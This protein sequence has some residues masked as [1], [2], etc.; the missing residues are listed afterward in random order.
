[1]KNFKVNTL[2]IIIASIFSGS[3]AYAVISSPTAPLVGF[4]SEYTQHNGAVTGR[5][6]LGGQLKVNPDVM[7]FSDKDEDIEDKT[8]RQYSWKIAGTEVSTTDTF[9]IPLDNQLIGLNVTLEVTPTTL[10]GSPLVGKVYQIG[11]LLDAGAT[12]GG[13]GG[14]IEPDSNA[15]PKVSALTILGKLE[16]NSNLTATYKWD[17]NG[18]EQTDKSTYRWNRGVAGSSVQAGV[19]TSSENVD[20]YTLVLDDAGQVIELSLTAVNGASVQGNTVTIDSTGKATDSNG[21]EGGGNNG[22]TGGDNGKVELLPAVDPLS[23]EIKF[24]STA[25]LD[26]NGVDGKQPVAGKD[27]LTAE[28]TF[29]P[30]TKTELSSYRFTWY[31]EGNVTPIATFD[32]VATYTPLAGPDGGQQG[33][34]IM[35]DVSLIKP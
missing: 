1:M 14:T 34:A 35:V 6:V 3:S 19:V 11:N 21:G 31:A 8:K 30:G 12:D 18:G 22:T 25:T 10:T 28:M 13:N 9:D 24:T 32:G 5:L 17:S 16:V 2:T 20:G 15:K 7:A 33:K 26:K 29:E 23:V 4:L 27:E